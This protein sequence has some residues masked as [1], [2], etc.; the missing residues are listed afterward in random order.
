MNYCGLCACECVYTWAHSSFFYFGVLEFYKLLVYI[1]HLH[2]FKKPQSVTCF[3]VVHTYTYQYK[4]HHLFICV[5]MLPYLQSM[6]FHVILGTSSNKQFIKDIFLGD[7]ILYISFFS[8][9]RFMLTVTSKLLRINNIYQS[10]G[11]Y[12]YIYICVVCVYCLAKK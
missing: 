3:S 7:Y 9:L 12:I 5:N 8:P 4:M 2:N 11:K 10:N 6:Y 1:T